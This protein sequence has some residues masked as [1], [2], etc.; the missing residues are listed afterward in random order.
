M[1]AYAMKDV[2][3]SEYARF[4]AAAGIAP[5]SYDAFTW[6]FFLDFCKAKQIAHSAIARFQEES[7]DFDPD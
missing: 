4:C 6:Q 5:V 1:M 2:G 3:Y 7:T